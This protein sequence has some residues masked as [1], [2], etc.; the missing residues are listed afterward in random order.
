M[1]F[2]SVAVVTLNAE[3]SLTSIDE[4]FL[5]I[6]SSSEEKRKKISIVSHEGFNNCC[7]LD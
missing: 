4:K 2:A 1:L 5:V 6:L 3:S 7:N